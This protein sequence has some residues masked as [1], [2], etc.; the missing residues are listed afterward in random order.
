MKTFKSFITES[1]NNWENEEPVEYSKHLEKTFGKPDEM[2]ISQLWWF[3][4]DGFKRIVV[5]D[6]YI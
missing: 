6:E 4:K 3:A 2:T 5:K 1:Y